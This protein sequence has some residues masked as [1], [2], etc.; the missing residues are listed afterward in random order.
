MLVIMET[1]FKHI[2]ALIGEPVRAGIMWALMDGK[3]M[4]ATELALTTDT[5]QQNL[6]MHLGKL[7][8]AD[9]LLVEK[10]GRHKY[11]KFARKEIAYALEAMTM[12]I[13]QPISKLSMVKFNEPTIMH[14]RT[15]Y[16]HLAGKIGVA[17]TDSLIKQK[18]IRSNNGVFGLSNKGNKWFSEFGIDIP[19]LKYQRRSFLRP[20]LDWSERRYHMAG[21]L[22]AAFLDKMF[23][24]DWIRR[25]KHSRIIVITS[26]GQKAF[27]EKFEVI[28]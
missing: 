14:C 27:N 22:P 12:L 10:L 28:S 13:P 15:C 16:D 3:A 23:H 18:I 17:I 21:S 9:L 26:K 5:S 25:T 24:L 7:L 8:E 20:C 4:S 6:S 11:Y 19:A 2:A 1:Q